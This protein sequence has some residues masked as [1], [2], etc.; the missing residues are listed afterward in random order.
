MKFQNYCHVSAIDAYKNFLRDALKKNRAPDNFNFCYGPGYVL[1]EFPGDIRLLMAYIVRNVNIGNLR[2]KLWWSF[3]RM[4]CWHTECKLEAADKPLLESCL[5]MLCDQDAM[6]AANG[7][8]YAANDMKFVTLAILYSLRIRESGEDLSNPLKQQL[9]DLLSP[10]GLLGNV[11]FPQ[12]MIPKV[13][14][15][16]RPLGD[17]L[18]K[19]VLRFIKYEDTLADRELGAAMGGV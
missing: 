5:N 10:R 4:L 12:T 18:S 6:I 11:G 17:T 7:G 1:G 16:S 2:C 14:P 15:V 8:R 3:F 9:I 13:N 19:Y